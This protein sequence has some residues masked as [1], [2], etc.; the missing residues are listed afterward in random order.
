MRLMLL[1]IFL[2]GSMAC[3][4]S[5]LP[6]EQWLVI[7]A[8][9]TSLEDVVIDL[10]KLGGR[11]AGIN[12]VNT[13]DCR[14]L[15]LDPFLVVGG[16]FGDRESA[17]EATDSWRVK[18]INDAYVE[19]CDV[20]ED[21]RL[22]LG[23]PLLDPSF[24]ALHIQPVNWDLDD[25]ISRVESLG[26]GMVVSIVPYYEADPEDI[27]EG[28]RTRVLLGRPAP[29]QQLSL[30][31]DCIDPEPAANRDYLALSCVTESAAD[32]LLH[33]TQVFNLDDG[34]TVTAYDRCREPR[35]HGGVLTCMSETVDAEGDL[36][37]E[38]RQHSIPEK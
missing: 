18:G 25:A 32:H 10:E 29:G 27:R 20:I 2:S 14:N 28:F 12:L 21:S 26:S 38:E 22:A 8:A 37:L 30:S 16:V 36:F 4:S 1:T 13:E 9:R 24:D 17:V 15:Q 3:T 5:S 7:L 19:S 11:T 33:R 34:Q 23:L 6:H 35:F 31:D